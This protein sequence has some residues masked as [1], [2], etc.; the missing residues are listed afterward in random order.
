MRPLLPPSLD[1]LTCIPTYALAT[2][3]SYSL[4][5]GIVDDLTQPLQIGRYWHLQVGLD[6]L[7]LHNFGNMH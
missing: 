4:D 7:C 2:H 1:H 3:E 5:P 6:T